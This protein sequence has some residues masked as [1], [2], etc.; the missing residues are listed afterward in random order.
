MLAQEFIT[1]PFA[2]ATRTRAAADALAVVPDHRGQARPAEFE[3]FADPP[4]EI[5]T[6]LSAESTL[7][8]GRQELSAPLRMLI[9]LLPAAALAGGVMWL[10]YDP[11]AVMRTI[12]PRGCPQP[13]TP[14]GA[15]GVCSHLHP[16]RKPAGLFRPCPLAPSAAGPR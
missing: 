8:Q 12:P 2:S 7:R 3:L 6:V 10:A 5:G 15:G 1:R 14:P 9:V 11:V 16:P 13:N 4:K